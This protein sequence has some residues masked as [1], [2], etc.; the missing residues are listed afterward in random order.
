MKLRERRMRKKF[1]LN[2]F[3]KAIHVS[4]SYLSQLE[5]GNKTNPSKEMM[6][7]IANALGGSVQDIFF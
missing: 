2:A 7:K 5:R 3:A 1:G 4:P 6:D